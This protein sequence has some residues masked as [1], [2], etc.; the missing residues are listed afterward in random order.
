[1]PTDSDQIYDERVKAR[2]EAKKRILEKANELFRERGYYGVTIEDIAKAVKLSKVSIYNHW[3]GKQDLL[4]EIHMNGHE[5]LLESLKKIYEKDEP[6]E[7][8]LRKSI[9]SHIYHAC[10]LMSPTTGALSQEYALPSNHMRNLIRIRDEYDGLLRKIIADG[11]RQ[12]V[13]LDIDPK[14][15]SYIIIGSVNYIQHW[16][17]PHGK[18]T[19]EEIAEYYADYLMKGILASQKKNK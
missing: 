18:L 10:S 5:L 11:V 9:I 7:E 19:K 15:T 12:G 13:F 6:P 17:L 4:Y 3:Q 1:M 2:K 8:K 16:Y 14:L